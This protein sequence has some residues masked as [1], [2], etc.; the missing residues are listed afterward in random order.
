MSKEAGMEGKVVEGAI[1]E[2]YGYDKSSEGQDS[3]VVTNL[4]EVKETI[5]D[6]AQKKEPAAEAL[7]EKLEGTL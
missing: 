7:S 3:E 1:V 4:S 6:M 2:G 5:V